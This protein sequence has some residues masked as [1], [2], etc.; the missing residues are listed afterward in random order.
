MQ[1]GFSH[2]LP[3]IP[4]I[5]FLLLNLL[6]A[7]Q[8][9]WAIAT[10]SAE[11]RARGLHTSV[12]FD[13]KMWVIGGFNS[14]RQNDVWYSED[15]A[16]W[17]LATA[18]APWSG[19]FSHTSVVFDNKI[20][21]MG[22]FTGSFRN[23]V[24]Y[25]E[26]GTNWIQATS[27]A[28]WSARCYF[29]SVV[30]DN[31]I[32]IL[33][34][35]NGNNLNDVWYSSDGVNWMCATDSAEWSARY[36]HTSLV[37]DNKMW[38]M[39]GTD[40]FDMSDV[41][42]SENGTNWM[43]AT[44]NIPS[45]EGL[46]SVI[47]DNKMW[48]IGGNA[49]PE[50]SR[51]DVWY[52]T[53]GDNWIQATPE[54]GWT[55]R[56]YH[57]SLVFNDKIW[58]IGGID[59]VGRK[60][61]VW[62]SNGSSLTLISPNGG[63]YWI[64]G[65]NQVIRWS[66]TRL[67][68]ARFRLLF[69]TNSGVNYPDTIAH[70]I[71]P[72]DTTYQWH[73]PYLN[74]SYY[75]KVMVQGLD[76]RD[77]VV[78][79]DESDGN[80]S[81]RTQTTII[82][83]NGGETW[84]GGNYQSIKWHTYAAGFAQYRFL[85]SID[86]GLTYPDTIANNIVPSETTLWWRAPFYNLTVCRIKAQ[87]LDTIGTVICEDASNGNFTIQTP[88]NVVT[89]NGGESWEGGTYQIIKWR[90]HTFGYTR[91]RLLLSK[92]RG[93]TF[94][95]TIT[96][97]VPP[98]DSIYS[99]LV[100]KLNNATCRIKIQI[101]DTTGQIVFEDIS[102]NNFAIHSFIFLA[103]SQYPMFRYDIQHTGRS[104]YNGSQTSQ[105][106][107]FYSTSQPII[108]SPVVSP[109]STIYFI[110]ENDTL[111]GIKFDGTKRWQYYL[112]QGTRSTPIIASDNTIYVGGGFGNLLCF[113][114]DLSILYWR[115]GTGSAISS[116][117]VISDSGI[118]YFGSED[119]Y[120]YALKP[121]STLN[122]SYNLGSPVYSSPAISQDQ[123]IYVG[124]IEGKL[125]SFNPQGLRT[126]E[127]TLPAALL[128]SPLVGPDGTIY[129]GC[130]NGRMYAIDR[131]G[132]VKWSYQTEDSITSSAAIDSTG[133]IYF[134]SYDGYVYALEDAG[135]QANLIWR[136]Q[137]Q[138][139]IRSSPSISTN[140]IIYIGSDDGN[141]YAI[142]IDG[143]LAWTRMTGNAVRSSPAIGAEGTIYIGSDDGRLYAIGYVPGVEEEVV[144]LEI[145]KS[146]KL[147]SGQPNPFASITNIRFGLPRTSPVV[148]KIYSSSGLILKNLVSETR[149]PGYHTV[150]WD[151]TDYT[152]KK[153]PAGIYFCCLETGNIKEV[154]KIIKVD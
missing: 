120:L 60:N 35:Y 138:G 42:F 2:K 4:V 53:N 34:G 129:I 37:F 96:H 111:Y 106:R 59:T 90:P 137:T 93:I 116:S 43:R 113:S 11:W 78:I 16:I 40:D 91:I 24:W 9:D 89:P 23:D 101:I 70:N 98:S 79:Q 1:K 38:I 107:W 10:D 67:V 54:A 75:C 105:V 76:S 25:S 68:V 133:I 124:S 50:Y 22:G 71:S 115:Y 153:V 118:I 81:I 131:F 126:W 94:L 132:V 146:F 29:T 84:R 82:A 117:P 140:G 21:V 104:P 121:D 69:S 46:S 51:N 44:G 27:S 109:D 143:S 136:Y 77:S 13:N 150:I 61:D 80:F 47:F 18:S 66:S 110:S 100:P 48:V 141:I 151:G 31:K 95:D 102:N 145:P 19:R 62:Y 20:W 72:L 8:M 5:F 49:N 92:N 85:L 154:K 74:T 125:F 26:D 52:S 103:T 86:G 83:P 32:W 41:W 134:G 28:S 55:P 142:N 119:G 128:S 15:G 65:S 73:V 33:G 36:D 12:V 139:K 148:L 56:G 88:V 64:G 97:N 149:N 17:T 114:N 112:E 39:G 45:R 63:S 122:W 99:W 130:C 7:Q 3:T 58:V 127:M 87:V 144:N 123:M 30:F 14:T 57:T 152:G 135:N 108:S 6:F 147:Y